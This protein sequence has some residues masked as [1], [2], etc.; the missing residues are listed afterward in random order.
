MFAIDRV[1]INFDDMM[2]VNAKLGFGGIIDRTV[3]EDDVLFLGANKHFFSSSLGRN[4]DH[5][6]AFGDQR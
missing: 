2:M 4:S 3:G 6:C 5:A 1:F